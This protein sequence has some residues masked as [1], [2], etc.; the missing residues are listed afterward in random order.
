VHFNAMLNTQRSVTNVSTLQQHANVT[1]TCLSL[2]RRSNEKQN[3]V[4]SIS[5]GRRLVPSAQHQPHVGGL[6][7]CIRDV[8]LYRALKSVT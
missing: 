8:V 3:S 6:G 4:V 5:N 7:K 2:M 1:W